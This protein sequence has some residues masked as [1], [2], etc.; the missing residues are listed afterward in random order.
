MLDKVKIDNKGRIVPLKGV[1]QLVTDLKADAKQID[2]DARSYIWAERQQAARTLQCWWPGQSLDGKKRD[3]ALQADGIRKRAFP[4]DGAPDARVRLADT[5]VTGFKRVVLAVIRRSVP[6]VKALNAQSTA[7]AATVQKWLR[8][9]FRVTLRREFIREARKALHWFLADT[10]AVAIFGCYWHREMGVKLEEMSTTDFVM[11]IQRYMPDMQADE[12]QMLVEQIMDETQDE[13]SVEV[14]LNAMNEL[15]LESG[16]DP[17]MDE[18]RARQ[19]VKGLREKDSADI[20]VPYVRRNEPKICAHRLLEDVF[21]HRSA[22]G[23]NIQRYY[24]REWVSAVDLEERVRS[25]NYDKAFVKQLV[26]E[27]AESGHAGESVFHEYVLGAEAYHRAAVK[28]AENKLREGQYELVH[29][30]LRAVDEN[31]LP[32]IYK[33]TFAGGA[34]VLAKPMAQEDYPLGFPLVI[35]QREVMDGYIWESRGFPELLT[36]DQDGAKVGEDTFNAYVELNTI[37][38]YSV[39]RRMANV[40]VVIKPMSKIPEDRKG[41]FEWKKLSEYPRA[42][43]EMRRETRRRVAEYTGHPDADVNPEQ[44]HQ[45]RQ[46]MIDTFMEGLSEVA[47]M[48]LSLYQEYAEDADIARVTGPGGVMLAQSVE[49]IQGDFDISMGFDERFLDMESMAA[50]SEFFQKALVPLDRQGQLKMNEVISFI[51]QGIDPEMEEMFMVPAPDA[52]QQEVDDEKKNIALMQAGVEPDM[53]EEGQNHGMRAQML[54]EWVE[55]NQDL[56]QMWPEKAREIFQ[57]RVQHLQFMVQ[58]QENAQIGRVGASQ[59]P[60]RPPAQG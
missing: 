22:E 51:L 30:Y 41:D 5:V 27:D 18:A 56:L 39:P 8:Q 14:M 45:A 10:P 7:N 17:F 54:M 12:A 28:T 57:R 24:V 42:N 15:A 49:D 19:V 31:G 47:R 52:A 16:L 40:A 58:Q 55:G 11:L 48:V 36:T 9:L 21:L 34:D 60:A 46:D 23:D 32:A 37:P 29:A 26:G 43:P 38:P 2:D 53:V 13:R 4:Y 44:T 20:P 35:V 3:E 1:S 6:R 59:G 50:F 25:E 33:A